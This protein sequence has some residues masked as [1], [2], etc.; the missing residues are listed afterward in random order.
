MTRAES[1]F[2]KGVLAVFAMVI[3]SPE[4]LAAMALSAAGYYIVI[5]ALLLA[6]KF[7]F[8]ENQ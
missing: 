2:F 4:N 1:V 3:T 5:S 8:G 6:V 7:V